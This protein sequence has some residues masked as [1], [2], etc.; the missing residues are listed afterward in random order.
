MNAQNEID[1]TPDAIDAN[2]RST[3]E[4]LI[5]SFAST[6]LSVV[7]GSPPDAVSDCVRRAAIALAD[8]ES[9]T[10]TGQ[11]QNIVVVCDH[12]TG[13]PLAALIDAIAQGVDR[14]TG[15]LVTRPNP[16]PRALCDVIGH[17]SERFQTSFT[18][19][20]DRFD[21][22]LAA[23]PLDA[24]NARFTEQLAQAIESAA[25][26]SRFVATIDPHNEHLL[27]RLTAR[28]PRPHGNVIRLRLESVP[29]PAGSAQ[30]GSTASRRTGETGSGEPMPAGF[31]ARDDGAID[32]AA[33]D[34]VLRGREQ[35]R[36]LKRSV[37]VG[38]AVLVAFAV[39]AAAM[40]VIRSR[41]PDPGTLLTRAHDAPVEPRRPPTTEPVRSPEPAT[42]ALPETGRPESPA[43]S[44][45]TVPGEQG[46]DEAQQTRSI[47]AA[48]MAPAEPAKGAAG[49]ADRPLAVVVP[50]GEAATRT[51]APATAPQPA[52]P[53]LPEPLPMPA[54]PAMKEDVAKAPAQP[55][56][57]P[58]RKLDA[59]PG[60]F[61]ID[62]PPGPPVPE[63]LVRDVPNP[64]RGPMIFLHI[65]SEAQRA[66]A[67][68]I[69]RGLARM[70]IVV[71]GIRVDESGPLRT[72]LR[73]FRAA[74]RDEANY[75]KS[76][77]GKFGMAPARVTQVAGQE[78]AAVRRHYEL[79]FAPPGG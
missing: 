36:R 28:L 64:E 66:K 31:S 40:M 21:H 30:P 46:R 74:E 33:T 63:R 55:D 10:A 73:Y 51:T 77:L 62:A 14:A 47:S 75:L 50:P 18:I 22:N 57:A 6:P 45:S 48:P 34:A 23:E 29:E 59:R 58:A 27:H 2:R 7:I 49:P 61:R 4:A 19:I 13:D 32:R 53:T 5:P 26:H 41:S 42:T 16:D 72:D 38:S 35:R 56:P 9:R 69:E 70:G 25:D 12:W 44:A 11:R 37:L 20:L 39:V 76:A 52:T 8:R 68:E 60:A 54:A 71:S 65:R 24:R 67:R 15:T 3:V 1:R 43:S 79:W 17:W 78:G